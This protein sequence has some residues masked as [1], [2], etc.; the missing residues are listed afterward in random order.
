MNLNNIFNK[1]NPLIGTYAGDLFNLCRPDYSSSDNIP[2]LIQSNVKYRCDTTSSKFAEP[3]FS[4]IPYYDIFGNRQIVQSGDILIRVN[5]TNVT[6]AITI[7]SI[8]PQESMVGF[9]SS[10]LCRIYN[11]YNQDDETD[12]LVYDNVYFDY[13]DSSYPGASLNRELANSLKIASTK[14]V[15][16]PRDNVDKAQMHLVEVDDNRTVTLPNGETI[17]FRRRWIIENYTTSGPYTVL[18][19]RTPE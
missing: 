10:K 3:D 2:V 11:Y 1:Y 13:L 8:Y 6:P 19:L 14:A 16:F 15:I 17:P 9:R 7:A 12:G 18:D 4:D 5:S